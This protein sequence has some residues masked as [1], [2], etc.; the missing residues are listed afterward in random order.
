LSEGSSAE[1]RVPTLFGEKLA[2]PLDGVVE[3]HAG[4]NGHSGGDVVDVSQ[5]GVV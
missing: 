4:I 5:G 3:P 2:R 1:R